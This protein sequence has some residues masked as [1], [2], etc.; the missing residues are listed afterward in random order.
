M[1]LIEDSVE[2][3]IY[4]ISVDRRMSHIARSHT[5]KG[6]GA[7]ETDVQE[8]QIEAANSAELQEASLS[9]MLA[10]GR[11]SGE[12]VGKEDLWNCLFRHRPRSGGALPGK[13]DSEVSRHLRAAAA[14][15]R[16]LE[17]RTRPT[18]V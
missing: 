4:Q 9:Q 12:M 16:Q 14:E 1:Y 6:K 13:A 7:N 3:S 5:V 2:K 11:E 18:E 15:G 8:S 10:K 17:M